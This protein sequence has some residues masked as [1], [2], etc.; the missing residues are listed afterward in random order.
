MLLAQDVMK[1][2]AA[3]LNDQGL[4]NNGIPSLFTYTAQIPYL[5]I[6]L[7][8]LR[9][10]LELN[11]VQASNKT[12]IDL[13]V[14]IGT[15]QLTLAELPRDLI[16]IQR[17]YE[18]T[19]GQTNEDFCDMT[20]VEFLPPYVMQTTYLVYWQW[21]GQNLNFIGAI[22]PRQLRMDYIASTLPRVIDPTDSIPII[23]AETFLLYRNAALCAEFIGENKSRADSLNGDAQMAYDRFIG[24]NTKGKQAIA[25]R[26]RPFNAGYRNGYV[27]GR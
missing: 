25:T 15:V 3:L 2:S 20:R 11:N 26:R 23:N 19:T 1:S 18:R 22:S 17:L 9:E 14:P 12:V 8:E 27:S 10:A 6:A 4:A 5:N 21:A 7:G 13:F 16:E 24:I